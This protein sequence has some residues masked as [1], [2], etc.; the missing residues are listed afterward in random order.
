MSTGPQ[1]IVMVLPNDGPGGMQS[2]AR[3]LTE[4]LRNAGEHVVLAVGGES[5]ENEVTLAPFSLRSLWSF[6]SALRRLVRESQASVLHAHGLRLAPALLMVPRVRRVITCH[7]IDPEKLPRMLFRLLRWSRMSVVACGAMPAEI[8]RAHGVNCTV[9]NNAIDIATTSRTR[10]EFDAHFGTNASDVVALWPARF[11]RQKGHDRLLDIVE[12]TANVPLH[13]VCCGEG[14][15]RD[16]IVTEI[17]RR[18]LSQRVSV[19]DYEAHASEWLSACD[20]MII[21]SRWEGQPLVALEALAAR[22]PVV[23]LIPSDLDVTVVTSTQE[24]SEKI[25]NWFGGQGEKPENSGLSDEA[26]QLHS[27]QFLVSSY[28]SLY[29]S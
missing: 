28:R 19:R 23:S 4:G 12:A 1:T 18:G 16:E 17:A 29:S 15:L 22:L 24:A 3:L 5:R 21:P 7:G 25:I 8:L 9:I 14:P 10:A 11:S 26:R 27:P 20:L 13:V 2:Q 6:A